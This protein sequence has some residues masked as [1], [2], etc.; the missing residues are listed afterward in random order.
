MEQRCLSTGTTGDDVNEYT[1][2]NGFDLASTV[3]FVDSYAVTQCPNPIAC[4]KI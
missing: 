2:P 3:T 1:P 4:S